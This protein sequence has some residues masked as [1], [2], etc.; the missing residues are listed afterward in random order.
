MKLD[1]TRVPH[2]DLEIVVCGPPLAFRIEAM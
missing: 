1:R 2:S